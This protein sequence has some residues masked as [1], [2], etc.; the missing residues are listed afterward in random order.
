MDDEY[1]TSPIGWL[2]CAIISVAVGIAY[3]SKG[4][5]GIV[6]GQSIQTLHDD[7]GIVVYDETFVG[8]TASVY[9]IAEVA[10]GLSL[11][12]LGFILP[13][14]DD[15]CNKRL[16]IQKLLPWQRK[17][18]IG[19]IFTLTISLLWICLGPFL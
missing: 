12:S 2:F 13:R 8:T 18:L 15:S 4:I 14:A 16:S 10:F 7:S 1:H 11:I 17:L 19:S 3:C 6:M 5:A 9:G